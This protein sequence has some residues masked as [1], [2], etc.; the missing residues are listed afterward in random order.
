MKYSAVSIIILFTAFLFLYTFSTLPGFSQSATIRCSK[1]VIDTVEAMEAIKYRV[2][3][4][5]TKCLQRIE[6]LQKQKSSVNDKDIPAIKDIEERIEDCR[7][8]LLTMPDSF[9]SEAWLNLYGT[10]DI[11]VKEIMVT[12]DAVG[13]D[14][15]PF[16]DLVA[17]FFPEEKDRVIFLEQFSAIGKFDGFIKDCIGVFPDNEKSDK[18]LIKSME[19]TVP[20]LRISL[21]FEAEGLLVEIC[22]SYWGNPTVKREGFEIKAFFPGSTDGVR[23]FYYFDGKEWRETVPRNKEC[24][25]Y[26]ECVDIIERQGAEPVLIKGNWSDEDRDLPS[27]FLVMS[28]ETLYENPHFPGDHNVLKYKIDSGSE[29][30]SGNCAIKTPDESWSSVFVI[31]NYEDSGKDVIAVEYMVSKEGYRLKKRDIYIPVRDTSGI[32]TGPRIKGCNFDRSVYLK[33]IAEGTLNYNN[34]KWY[35]KDL[36][37]K[38]L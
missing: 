25:S 29:I 33:K 11:P 38:G 37:S 12:R 8:D 34:D 17:H 22:D 32:M 4:R 2:N 18:I 35:M 21:G 27:S 15:I 9:S 13:I 31:R 19:E 6:E 16:L 10:S 28:D 3:D 23:L 20:P 7:N 1:T 36:P 30:L 26:D 14:T 5:N 24:L